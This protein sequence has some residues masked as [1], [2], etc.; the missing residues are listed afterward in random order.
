MEVQSFE[1]PLVDAAGGIIPATAEVDC[2]DWTESGFHKSEVRLVVR[3]AAG[4]TAVADWKHP[5][6]P[7]LQPVHR[8]LL[9][10]K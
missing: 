2:R 6:R 7:G 8:A 5:T 10:C 1:S 3:W 4:E 9:N